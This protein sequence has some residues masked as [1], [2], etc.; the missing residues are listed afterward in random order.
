M[1]SK[2]VDPRVIDLCN[3]YIHGDMSRRSFLRRLTEV[4]GCAAAASTI[5]PLLGSN[6]AWGQQVAVDDVRLNEVGAKYA[7]SYGENLRVKTTEDGRIHSFEV[8]QNDSWKSVP[9]R[10]DEQG[11][12]WYVR[13]S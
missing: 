10:T 3:D 5:L 6:R 1:K 4:I 13:D 8:R 11:T 2:H 7:G 9:F 12:S